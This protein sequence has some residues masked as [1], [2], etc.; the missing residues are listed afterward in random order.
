MF[1]KGDAEHY[2]G[3]EASHPVSPF[4]PAIAA[5]EEEIGLKRDYR[6]AHTN[7]NQQIDTV[8]WAERPEVRQKWEELRER[9]NLEKDTWDKA[10]WRFIPHLFARSVVLV[11][12]TDTWEA[13]KETF[14][15]EEAFG[16]LEKEGI[17]LPASNPTV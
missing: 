1:P 17:L 8:K 10:T 2:P 12:W 5:H 4:T 7:V 6:G 14:A 9:Y 11:T 15:F 3:Y 13:F 16:A